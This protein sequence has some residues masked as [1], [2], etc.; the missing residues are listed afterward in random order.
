MNKTNSIYI[1]DYVC[2]DRIIK[3]LYYY[4]THKKH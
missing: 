4:P 2:T 1:M 3:Y